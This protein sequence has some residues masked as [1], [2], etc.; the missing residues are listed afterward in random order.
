M[1]EDLAAV[2]AHWQVLRQIGSKY[3]A[4]CRQKGWYQ[5]LSVDSS[6]QIAS[7]EAAA[8]AFDRTAALI[9]A[10]ID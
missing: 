1:T 7:L 10:Q 3:L 8:V 4:N 6:F 5:Q 9:V 2:L